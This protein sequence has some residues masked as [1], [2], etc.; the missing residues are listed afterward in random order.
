MANPSQEAQ[1]NAQHNSYQRWYYESINKKTM[2]PSAGARYIGRQIDRMARI[3]QLDE[4]EN[5]LEVG[6][7]Q[8]RYSVPM[9]DVGYSLTCLDLSPV[10]LQRMLDAA[11]TPPRQV[12]ACDLAEVAAHTSERFDRAIG[13]FTLH[14]MHDLDDIFLGLAKVLK[15]GAVVAF[16]EPVAWNPLYYIQIALTPRMTWKGD[17]GVARMRP[18]LVLPALER[19]GFVDARSTAFGFF[20]PFITNR[21]WGATLETLLER[22]RVFSPLHAF[23][24]F[25]A[26]YRG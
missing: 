2:R 26:T 23:Q 24:I 7:G 22:A 6:C 21:G 20:P 17:G 4:A 5:I 25:S 16:C 1:S 9:L 19:A 12:I 8:G 14:H 10:L 18:G 15:P 3:A 11:R 13:F